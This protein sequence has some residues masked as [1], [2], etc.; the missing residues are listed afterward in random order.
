MLVSGTAIGLIASAD[1][2]VA[3][4]SVN[5][6]DDIWRGIVADYLDPN[7]DG[8]LSPSEISAV[9]L[10]DVSGFLEAKYG[11]DTPVEINDLTGIEHFTALRTLRVGGI[12]LETLNVYP[13]VALRS[14][15]CQG[16]YLE[17]LN[18]LNNEELIELNCSANFIKSLLVSLN[19]NLTKLICHTNE[20]KSIDL[21]H[22]AQLEYLSIF[23]NELTT[24]NLSANPLLSTLNCSN[25]HLKTLDLSGNPLLSE[26]NEDFISNQTV[27]AVANYSAEDGSIYAD[28]DIDNSSR[29]VSTSLDRVEEFEETVVYVK[30]YDGSSFV[31][32]EPE[33]ILEGID[34]YYNV[35]LEGAA[36]MRVHVNVSKDFYIVRYY[37]SE[38]L[39]NKIGEEVVNGGAS[40]TF[41][42]PEAPLCKTFIQWNDELSEIN[43]DIQTYAIWQDNHNLQRSFENGTVHIT[44]S[45]GCGLDESYIFSESINARTNDD[46]FVSYLDVNSD[47]IINAKDFARLLKG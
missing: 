34:Y 31:T 42:N 29:I 28:F 46:N 25:N 10:I 38:A 18:L 47:G 7:S 6:K 20:I 12:G 3:I 5:F 36:N 27:S 4:N 19:T 45:K 26:I 30:G 23:Q 24:L 11:E 16:N 40:A 9:T 39:E 1:D 8:T 33:Q 43:S 2:G 32:Y 35:N 14:L 37:D 21:T 15:T 41:T 13:L 17:S 22:N 44:C